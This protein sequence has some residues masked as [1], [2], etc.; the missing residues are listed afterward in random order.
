MRLPTVQTKKKVSCLVRQELKLQFDEL[1]QVSKEK[2]T[3]EMAG[4]VRAAEQKVAS[5]KMQLSEQQQ[6]I[7]TSQQQLANRHNQRATV[8]QPENFTT[9]KGDRNDLGPLQV[10][11][12][13]FLVIKE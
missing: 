9:A 5:L 7:E 13:T 2:D 3:V 11:I 4:F 8:A 10:W 6:Q 1:Q 12:C